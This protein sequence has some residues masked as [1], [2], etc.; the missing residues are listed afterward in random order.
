MGLRPNSYS[1]FYYSWYLYVLL[2]FY[3]KKIIDW[4]KG[5]CE[6]FLLK[7]TCYFQA[8]SIPYLP[9][10]FLP[11]FWLEL[12]FIDYLVISLGQIELSLF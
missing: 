1:F 6:S 11:Y 4:V 5:V 3:I 2:P 8:K 10:N 7:F 12:A 9:I